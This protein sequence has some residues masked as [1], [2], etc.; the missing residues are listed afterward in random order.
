MDYTA[1]ALGRAIRRLREEHEPPMTQQELGERADYRGGA[2]VSISRI[3]SGT[4]RPR[5]DK[6]AAIA[7]ALGLTPR[8]LEVAASREARAET[9]RGGNTAAPQKATRKRDLNE[10]LK[11]VQERTKLRTDAVAVLGAAFNEAHDSARDRFFLRLV[12][13]GQSIE[14]VPLP[15]LPPETGVVSGAHD[16]RAHQASRTTNALSNK[17][18]AALLGGAG[19]AALGGATGAAAAYATFS[20]AAVFGTASTGAAI[21]GLSGIAATNA[22]LALLGGGALAAGGGGIAAGTLLLTG[23]V[24]APV[25]VL[26]AGGLY[27]ASRRRTKA[28][29]ERLTAQVEDAEAQLDTSQAGFDLLVDTLEKATSILDYVGVHAAHAL[30]KWNSRLGPRPLDWESLNPSQQQSY[31]EFIDIAACELVVDSIDA[32]RFITVVPDHL[33]KLAVDVAGI[34]RHADSTVRALV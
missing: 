31:R 12:E 3:E 17:I 16:D 6:L 28:E 27:F 5:P 8:Q 29:E 33:E 1:V 24:A 30:T 20:A 25:A 34:L 19:G 14:G 22:T 26:A 21:S 13:I 7:L 10:R 11:R 18:T 2:G 32:T 9:L 23:I 4:T 15:E